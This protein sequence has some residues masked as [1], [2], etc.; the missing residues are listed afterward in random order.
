MTNSAWKRGKTVTW[1]LDSTLTTGLI[2]D[3]ASGFY[4]RGTAMCKG[5]KVCLESTKKLNVAE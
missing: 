4:C 5:H 2:N 3:G 1:W